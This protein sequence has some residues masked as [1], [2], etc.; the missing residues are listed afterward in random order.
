M[1]RT[2]LILL[3]CVLGFYIIFAQ[4]QTKSIK[5][6]DNTLSKNE[7]RY[8]ERM[9]DYEIEFFNTIFLHSKY[10]ELNVDI[11]VFSKYAAYLAYQHE[12]GKNIHIRSGGFYSH[13]DNQIVICKDQFEKSFLSACYHELSHFLLSERTMHAPMWLNEG[14]ATYMDNVK[15]SSKDIKHEQEQYLVTR[16]KTMIELKDINLR[17]FVSWSYKEFSEASFSHDSYGYAIAHCMTHL[18][19]DNK[20]SA[21]NIIRAVCNERMATVEA[22]DLHYTGGFDQFEKDFFNRYS[23]N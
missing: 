13:R 16:V 4:E 9:I 14:I 18:M 17:E 2:S 19:M 15:I 20:E 22:F 7:R 1:K 3:L 11:I 8:L 5:D 21:F 12:I 6:V 23:S 10:V